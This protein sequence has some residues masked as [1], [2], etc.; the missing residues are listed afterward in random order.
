MKK[1][2]LAATLVF[3]V[4]MVNGQSPVK[5]SYKV[6]KIKDKIYEI[7]LEAFMDNEWHIYSQTTPEGG[8][9]P[10]AFSFSKNPL[11]TFD[12]SVK[13]VG[14]LEEHFEPLFGVKVKQYSDK[15]QF[16]Q[17]IKLKATVKTAVNVYIEF[18]A[19]NDA[20]CMPPAKQ[21][22]LISLH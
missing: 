15:V 7:H 8:P 12:G 6:Q 16:I 14:N 13:E 21:T 17:I 11:V 5:W 4:A 22:F 1:I 18:M 10:T 19:C 9:I 2:I 3:T 20:E